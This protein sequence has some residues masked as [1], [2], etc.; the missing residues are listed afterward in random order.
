MPQ[1]KVTKMST[2]QALKVAQRLNLEAVTNEQLQKSP[3]IQALLKLN[4]DLLAG[5]E[6]FKILWAAQG[7]CVEAFAAQEKLRE[8]TPLEKDAVAACHTATQLLALT[9]KKLGA[10]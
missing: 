2:E 9:G 6:L 4:E 8:L 7:K 10:A 3:A 1:P 5:K